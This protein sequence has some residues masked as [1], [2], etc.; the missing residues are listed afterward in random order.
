MWPISKDGRIDRLVVFATL[1][2]NEIAPVGELAF[3]GRGRRQSIFRYAGS[4]L[5]RAN[6][7]FPVAP[8]LPLRAKAELSNPSEVPLAFYDAAPDGWGRSVLAQAFPNQVWGMAELLAGAGDDRTGQLRFGPDPDSGPQQF[9]PGEPMFEMPDGDALLEDLLDAAVAVDEGRPRSH[10]LHLL[11]RSS[12]DIGGAR[13]KTHIM[14]NGRSWIA[15]FPAVGDSFDEPRVE[16]VCLDLAEACG[17]DVPQR[18]VIRI[19]GRSVMLVERF[20]RGAEGQRHGY[21]SAATLLKQ[22]PTEYATMSTYS[23]L[24]TV[25][26]EKGVVPFEAELFRRLLFNCF[27][28]NTDDHTRNHAFLYLDGVWTLSPAFDLVPS[29]RPRLVL[30]PAPKIDPKPDPL[31]AFMAYPMFRLDWQA[32]SDIYSQ[33]ASGLAKLEAILEQ[34]EISAKDRETLKVWMPTAF[35]PPPCPAAV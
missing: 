22:P 6:D 3:E 33:V 35:S 5:K 18:D 14:R 34:R 30:A 10:H 7:K 17:I 19:A 20:D 31:L 11:F 2:G 9:G 23:E 32:A 12:S 8:T 28:H 27:I 24:A 4:W 29:Q 25:A 1:P 26:R 13:P 16:T 15:K 21:T